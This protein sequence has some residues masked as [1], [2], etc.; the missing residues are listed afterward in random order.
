MSSSVSI[1]SMRYGNTLI[2]KEHLAYVD[3]KALKKKIEGIA[4]ISCALQKNEHLTLQISS[5]C[6]KIIAKE[7]ICI[8]GHKAKEILSGCLKATAFCQNTGKFQKVSSLNPAFLQKCE[9]VNS[10]AQKAISEYSQA[11]LSSKT[12]FTDNL[13]TTGWMMVDDHGF[14]TAIANVIDKTR[15]KALDFFGS[16]IGTILGGINAVGDLKEVAKESKIGDSTRSLKHVLTLTKAVSLFLNSILEILGA[17]GQAD[18]C[19]A[20]LLASYFGRA[21]GVSSISANI[22]D[23]CEGYAFLSEMNSYATCQKLT[24]KEKILSQLNLLKEKL[25]YSQ[26]E[27]QASDIEK[28]FLEKGSLQDKESSKEVAFKNLLKTKCNFFKKLTDRSTTKKLLEN[29]DANILALQ[30]NEQES[31]AEH[32]LTRKGISFAKGEALFTLAKTASLSEKEKNSITQK[33][34]EEFKAKILQEEKTLSGVQ[35]SAKE[36]MEKKDLR[37]KEQEESIE[38]ALKQAMCAK[39]PLGCSEQLK[40]AVIANVESIESVAKVR[41]S[42]KG[43]LY[44]ALF[45][46]TLKAAGIILWFASDVTLSVFGAPI[47]LF[48]SLLTIVWAVWSTYGCFSEY[49][50]LGIFLASVLLFVMTV[51]GLSLFSLTLPYQLLAGGI[52][53]LAWGIFSYIGYAKA[54]HGRKNDGDTEV[55]DCV[56]N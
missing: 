7:T 11:F 25:S 48:S 41:D 37:A 22:L 33:V 45:L 38:L 32:I 23:L 46:T 27:I 30:K 36:K 18:T 35:E 12:R 47:K 52:L 34:K 50:T 3:L 39:L 9:K 19:V 53:L 16:V 28:E 13:S 5:N 15:T 1:D 24:E 43:N 31:A 17:F 49:G 55:G 8:T 14:F 26:E 51:C 42:V 29:I 56:A 40:K 10:I 6:L 2:S 4:Q 44:N 21:Y 20:N 54:I